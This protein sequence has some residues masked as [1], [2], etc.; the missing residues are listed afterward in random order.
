MSRSKPLRSSTGLP[1]PTRSLPPTPR[2]STSTRLPHDVLGTHFFSPANVMRLLEIVRGK[3]T[4]HQAIATALAL[5]RTLGKVPV[6]V[7]NC[8]GFVGNRMLARRSIE[9][10]RLLL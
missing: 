2:R 9:S 4:S 3:A 7:G 6:V 10:E 8:D 5:G 1:G